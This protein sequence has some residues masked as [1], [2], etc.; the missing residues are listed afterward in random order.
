MEA[1]L[2]AG[3]PQKSIDTVA[4]AKKQAVARRRDSIVGVS[5]YANPAEKP[6]DIPFT[7]AAAFHKRRAQQVVS[8]RTSMDDAD[9]EVVLKR[10]SNIVSIRGEGLFAECL[11]AASAGATLGEI[12]RAIRIH[13]HPCAPVSPVNITRAAIPFERLRAAVDR[14]VAAGRPRPQ[15]FLCNMGS[16]KEHKGRADFSRGFFAAGGYEVISP[17][18]FPNPEAAVKAFVESGAAIAVLCS[19]DENYPALVSPLVQGLR[20]AKAGAFIALAGYPLEQVETCR[21]AGVDEF[22]HIRADAAA[23]LASFHARLGIEL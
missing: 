13:D 21:K 5:Q 9:S 16:L 18:G 19:T 3:F 7:E 1:A 17:K 23:V 20:A 22:V 10:L 8:H 15:V 14:E 6:L 2:R 11:E 4:A 12:V